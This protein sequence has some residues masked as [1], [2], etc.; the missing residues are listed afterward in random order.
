[1]YGFWGCGEFRIVFTLFRWVL[2]LS[3]LVDFCLMALRGRMGGMGIV[4]V[5]FFLYSLSKTLIKIIFKKKE[6]WSA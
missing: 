4:P 2:F 5:L 6:A 3:S 1:M